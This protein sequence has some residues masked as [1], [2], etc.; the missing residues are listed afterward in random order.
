MLG[1]FISVISVSLLALQGAPVTKVFVQGA[2]TALIPA[3]LM[4]ICIV[5]MNQL[6]DVEIDKVSIFPSQIL[7][8]VLQRGV[9]LERPP[10]NFPQCQ[11]NKPYLPLAS[12]EFD[13]NTGV[14]IVAVTGT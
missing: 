6:Y 12:G 2:L 14:A 11:V 9:P 4:N 13:M 10:T 7:P 1:T 3:L 8:T 5:G